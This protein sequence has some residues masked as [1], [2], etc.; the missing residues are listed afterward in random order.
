MQLQFYC[1]TAG[2]ITADFSVT[3]QL[4]RWGWEAP[5]A[6]I[7][8]QRPAH[9]SWCR[10]LRATARRILITSKNE[11]TTTLGNLFQCSDSLAVKS[12]FL[13][14][15]GIPCISVCP[16]CIMLLQQ[17]PQR[18]VWLHPLCS[19]P[20]GVYI[21]YTKILRAFSSWGYIIPS[22]S[23]AFPTSKRSTVFVALFWM[24]TIKLHLSSTENPEPDT[25]L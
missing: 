14:L 24:H 4:N 25:A 16:H 2:K 18:R 12:A 10:L 1:N 9:T 23:S 13:C 15:K 22:L 6:I 7:Y 21:L 17:V 8:F 19:L 11:D 20:S 3:K 5:L